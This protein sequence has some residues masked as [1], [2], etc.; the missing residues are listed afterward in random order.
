MDGS[1]MVVDVTPSK[2]KAAAKNG[3]SNGKA[4]NGR[5]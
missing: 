3:K 2:P 4:K 1:P 5:R